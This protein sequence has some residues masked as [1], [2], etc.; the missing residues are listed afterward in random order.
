[1]KNIEEW[2]PFDVDDSCF[3]AARKYVTVQNGDVFMN[4]GEMLQA[5][6][7]IPDTSRQSS[8]SKTIAEIGDVTALQRWFLLKASIGNR[9][10]H[11]IR[12][13]YM[14]LDNGHEYEDVED[15]I[16]QTN[17]KLN[18]PLP[19]REIQATIMKTARKRLREKTDGNNEHNNVQF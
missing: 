14:L 19:H 4:N 1:M 3:E 15:I 9:N 18:E 5:L 6:D 8:L 17:D 11:M 2:L 7:F 13:A 10:N 12:L 16:I